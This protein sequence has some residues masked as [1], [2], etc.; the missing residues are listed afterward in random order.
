MSRDPLSFLGYPRP[1]GSVGVRNYVL[2]IPAGLIADRICDF[3]TG[4]KRIVTSDWGSGWTSRD[5]ETIARLYF[6]LG[7]NPNVYGVIL[8]GGNPKGGYPELTNERIASEIAKSGKRVEVLDGG[9]LGGTMRTI[10]QGTLLAREMAWEASRVERERF[11]LDKL[12]IGTKCGASDPTSGMVGNPAVGYLYDRVVEQ[13]GTCLFGE[14]TEI[15]GAEQILARRA[16]TP[17]VAEEILR[18][19]RFIEDRA[20]ATGEDIRSINPVPANIEAGI[21]TL[22]EKSLGAIHKS[23]SSPIQGVLKYAERPNGK[24]LYFCDNWQNAPSIFAGYAASGC[25]L[26][27]YQLGG[28]GGAAMSPSAVPVTNIL[29]PS[30]GQVAPLIWASAS[31]FTHA[32]TKGSLDY[33]SGTVIEGTETPEEV[34]ERLLR[35]V[36]ETASG[37][38]TKG[39][40]LNYTC[41]TSIYLLDPVF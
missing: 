2:V 40:T 36:V 4:T 19:A 32:R 34:G 9:A 23:G 22:E 10:E 25:Q 24:G 29:D 5:R 17:E 16:A 12:M 41:P 33:Y 18:A 3:V 13:G 31:P 1:D 26:V 21:S 11:G 7:R 15:I 35:L 20:L 14:T 37:G 30:L 6:G 28:T 39:E 8:Y 27:I 38:L